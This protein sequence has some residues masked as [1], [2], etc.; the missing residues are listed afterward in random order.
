[1]TT[2]S[3][4]VLSEVRGPGPYSWDWT[5]WMP[6]E[7]LP[8]LPPMTQRECDDG[9]GPNTRLYRPV[10]RFSSSL[11]TPVSQVT[12]RASGL[13]SPIR[14]RYLEWSMT[15]AA[16]TVSPD[17]LVPPPRFRIGAPNS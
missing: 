5:E 15:T 12:S 16:L 7:L 11:I 2:S 1:M 4:C 8:T 6:Q 13:I 14:V 3:A 17:R 10:C 9:S